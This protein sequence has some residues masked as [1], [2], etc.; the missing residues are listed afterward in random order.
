MV[1]QPEVAPMS[2]Q[3]SD[4]TS[5][6]QDYLK[7]PIEH[8]NMADHN[9]VSLVDSMRRMAFS[10]RDLYRA[11]SIYNRML[12]D[13]ECGIILCLAGSLISAGLKKIFSDLI[14]NNMVD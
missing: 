13:E 7:E 10:G 11:A 9:V 2:H 6:K 4:K 14:R 3:S 12:Q 1:L 8:F 5:K